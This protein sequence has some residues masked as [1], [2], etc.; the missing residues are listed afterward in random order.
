MLTLWEDYENASSPE[1]KLAKAFDKL[2]TMLQHTQG[3]N[4][5][6]FDYAFNLRY[7]KQYTQ[8]NQQ[9]KALRELIDHDTQQRLLAAN[10]NT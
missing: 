5:A 3:Q 6:D 4:P 1:A 9:T 10:N 7:G 2:E 8:L